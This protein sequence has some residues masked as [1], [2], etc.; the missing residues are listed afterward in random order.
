M[1]LI[2]RNCHKSIEQGLINSGGIPQYLVPTRNRHGVIG[3]IPPSTLEPQIIKRAIAQNPLVL[4]Q[5]EKEREHHHLKQQ[6]Q[7]QQ[8]Q[9]SSQHPSAHL[10]APGLAPVYAVMTNCTYDGLTV[11]VARAER[12]LGAMVDRVHFGACG[13]RGQV[14]RV[15]LTLRGNG[16]EG[17]RFSSHHAAMPCHAIPCH[18]MM[19]DEAWWAYARFNPLYDRRYAMRGE[20]KDHPRDG[21][22]VY[23]TQ[24]THKLL[25]ALSQATFIHVREGRAAIPHHIFNEV[26]KVGL[27]LVVC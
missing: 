19:A 2:D 14:V 21:P 18:A 25:A 20:P 7:Q 4:Q 17:R 13:A 12:L 10:H 15:G 24:S 5:H 8:Q 9:K 11:D 27:C 3:P 23:A 1:A 22:T 26:V 16:R 6:Q